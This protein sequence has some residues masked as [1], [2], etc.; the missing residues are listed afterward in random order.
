VED[1]KVYRLNDNNSIF[2]IVPLNLQREWMTETENKFA[3]KCLPLN[4]ANQYGWA[5]LNPVDFSVSWYGGAHGDDVD[6]FSNDP[7]FVDDIIVSHF[8]EGTFTITLD[9]IIKTPEG[10]ST[11][12][13][14]IPNKIE[15]LIKPLDA[16]V[17][18][19]WL[20]YTFTYNF[21]F[22][23][24]GVVHFKKDEPLFCFFPIERNTVENFK[25]SELPIS[26]NL[27]MKDDFE[28]LSNL[29]ITAA[30]NSSG[31]KVL[32][33]FYNLMKAPHKIFNVKNHVGRLRFGGKPDRID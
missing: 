21:K 28:K 2:R 24:V 13:R 33:R 22:N 8:G 3:Y 19:D 7:N 25:I 4:I 10:Y 16:I 29:R 20:P 1:I 6:V 14:G 31:K 18:T 12:I 17:E 5:V 9:F 23:D 15:K 27:E 32:Q 30:E 11:Y 26:G